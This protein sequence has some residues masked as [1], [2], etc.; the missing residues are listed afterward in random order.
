MI[1]LRI[2]YNTFGFN[3]SEWHKIDVQKNT[4]TVLECWVPFVGMSDPVESREIVGERKLK[5]LKFLNRR[6]D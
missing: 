3:V 4:L 6:K 5:L 1:A 2:H